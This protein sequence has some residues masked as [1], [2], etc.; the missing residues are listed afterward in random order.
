MQ[1]DP[2]NW[3]F[4][5]YPPN[6]TIARLVGDNPVLLALNPPPQPKPPD[7]HDATELT[8]HVDIF[9]WTFFDE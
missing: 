7:V 5:E 3:S 4:R 6:S 8:L 1:L 2:R 9:S